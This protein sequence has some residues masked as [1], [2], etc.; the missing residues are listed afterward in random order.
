M[1]RRIWQDS[2]QKLKRLFKDG[3]KLFHI[4]FVGEEAVDHGGPLKEYFTLI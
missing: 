3:I 4:G 2:V 1:R